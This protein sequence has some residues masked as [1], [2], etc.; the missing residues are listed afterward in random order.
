M[1][2]LPL[3]IRSAGQSSSTVVAVGFLFTFAVAQTLR[4]MLCH[5][6]LGGCDDCICLLLVTGDKKNV[7]IELMEERAL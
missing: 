5:F 4:S 3:E 6:K 7:P 2:I 1:V